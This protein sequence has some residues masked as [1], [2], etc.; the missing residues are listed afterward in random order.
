MM[1]D[2]IGCICRSIL[3]LEHEVRPRACQVKSRKLSIQSSCIADHL[4]IETMLVYEFFG[5][6]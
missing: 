3:T 6:Q 2:T 4:F 5:M 1:V